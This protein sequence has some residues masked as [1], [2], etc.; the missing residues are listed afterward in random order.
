MA[1]RLWSPAA[2]I[3]AFGALGV[4]STTARPASTATSCALSSFATRRTSSYGSLSSS[5]LSPLGTST[6]P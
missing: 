1:R 2:L 3:S 5:L 4:P 6:S